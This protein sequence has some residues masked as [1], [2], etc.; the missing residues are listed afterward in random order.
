MGSNPSRR[1]EFISDND[2]TYAGPVFFQVL[3]DENL[4]QDKAGLRDYPRLVHLFVGIR[5]R[6]NMKE[7]LGSHAY[8]R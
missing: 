6:P 5:A 8:F 2:S 1:G 7:F 3:H 4:T